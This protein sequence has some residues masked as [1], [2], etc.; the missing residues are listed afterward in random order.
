MLCV[1]MKVL[2]HASVK[3]ETE[4]LKQVN[5]LKFC[6]YWLFSSDIMAGKGLITWGAEQSPNWT[7][8]VELMPATRILINLLPINSFTEK[9]K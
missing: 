6:T 9:S 1:L 3:M 4:R 5:G 8:M 7:K 2:P